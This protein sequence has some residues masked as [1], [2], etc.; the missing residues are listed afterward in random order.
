M[1]PILWVLDICAAIMYGIGIGGVFILRNEP[2]MWFSFSAALLLPT[3]C[4]R[5][6]DVVDLAYED[7][8]ED[9]DFEDL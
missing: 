8:K 9:I 2:A 6:H 4:D 7:E 5:I 3:L 1:K